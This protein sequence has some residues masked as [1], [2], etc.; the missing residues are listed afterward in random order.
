[1]SA[2]EEIA[3]PHRLRQ[4]EGQR[5]GTVGDQ[6]HGVRRTFD[7]H[8]AGVAER[9]VAMGP[10]LDGGVG[11]P[12][13]GGRLGVGVGADVDVEQVALRPAGARVRAGQPL[14]AAD[15][16]SRCTDRGA[17]RDRFE[18]Q[19]EQGAEVVAREQPRAVVREPP[20]VDRPAAHGRAAVGTAGNV[21]TGRAPGSPAALPHEVST[22]TAAPAPRRLQIPPHIPRARIPLPWITVSPA[23]LPSLLLHRNLPPGRGTH[24]CTP[25]KVGRPP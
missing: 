10:V 3:D 11:P 24:P 12:L 13:P 16:G 6:Q 17:H 1:V 8:P 2:A 22:S 4:Y 23:P 14:G 7:E 19:P 15:G 21:G 20:L 25:P 5:L 9:D 18:R